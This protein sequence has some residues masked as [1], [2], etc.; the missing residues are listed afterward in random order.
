MLV[1]VSFLGLVVPRSESKFSNGYTHALLDEHFVATWC[2]SCLTDEPNVMKVY[3]DLAGS[4]FVV[5]YHLSDEFSNPKGESQSLQYQVHSIPYHVLDGGYWTGKGTVYYADMKNPATRPVHAI[6]LAIRK[7]FNNGT[8][9]YEGSVQE[10]DGKPFVGYL[11]VY[12]TENRLHS[13]GIEWNFVFRDF[14]ISKQ[15]A[16]GPNAF[17]LFSGTWTISS[18]VKAE[19]ILVIAAV[20]DNSTADYY[21]P[22]AIQAIDDNKSGQVVPEMGAPV[23]VMIMILLTAAVLVGMRKYRKVTVPP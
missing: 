21:G 13:E 22:Y 18:N 5:S 9:Q 10:M 14:G 17:S 6:G 12:I 20:F 23:Q 1:S 15:L 11:R 7:L 4:F 2:P 3:N 19:N 16:I 8:L